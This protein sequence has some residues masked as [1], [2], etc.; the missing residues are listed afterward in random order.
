MLLLDSTQAWQYLTEDAS[1]LQGLPDYAM[2][3]LRQLAE[4][5]EL[6]G[7]RVTLDIT[8]EVRPGAEGA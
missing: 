3:M 4:Q 1:E 2:S 6:A 7:Y 5:K 8:F